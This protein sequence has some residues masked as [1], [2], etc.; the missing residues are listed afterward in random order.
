MLV[1][2]DEERLSKMKIFPETTSADV[3]S[4]FTGI[5]TANMG[6]V[7]AVFAAMFGVGWLLTRLNRARS[8]KI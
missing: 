4:G 6:V 7:I 2:P 1:N 3:I 8:G 5:V